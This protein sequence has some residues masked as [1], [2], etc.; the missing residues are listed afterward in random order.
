MNTLGKIKFPPLVFYGKIFK[1]VEN[2]DADENVKSCNG[3]ILEFLSPVDVVIYPQLHDT[4]QMDPFHDRYQHI[5]VRDS[6]CFQ[7][8]GNCTTF[9]QF[10]DF[11]SEDRTD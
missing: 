1:A 9:T 3:K 11:H 6:L 8:S 7:A 4:A 5:A 2:A 10:G